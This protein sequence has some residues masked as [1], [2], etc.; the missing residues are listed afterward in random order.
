MLNLNMNVALLIIATGKYDVF[1]EPL[2]Q[3]VKKHF[4]TD[5]N[6]IKVVFHDRPEPYN[7]VVNVRIEH[8][9]WPAPTL[10]RY[11]WFYEHLAKNQVIAGLGADYLFYVD[12][13]ALFI[14]DV[15]KE[16]LK[17]DSGLMVA[18]QH[19]GFASGGWGSP[20]VVE[21]SMA[22]IAPE[23]RK[24]YCM[25]GFQGGPTNRFLA[26]CHE[27]SDDIEIDAQN[28]VMA[29]WHD[30][31]HFNRY[32]SQRFS[33]FWVLPPTFMMAEE[34]PNAENAF[35]WALKKNHDEIRAH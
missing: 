9:P 26:M 13:D 15:T 32:V 6:V 17:L 24:T 29:E 3:S 35:V 27:L 2:L 1:V 28:G 14:K 34:M 16:T 33:E 11:K 30:E 12:V 7:D 5:C 19:C 21:N 18:A 10:Y 31:S 8:Q 4:L 22:Y 20:N 23:Q 25:G